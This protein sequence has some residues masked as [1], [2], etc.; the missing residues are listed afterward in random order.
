LV[1]QTPSQQNWQAQCAL[2]RPGVMRLWS[3]QAIAHGSESVM[4]FQW[5][6]T[7]GGIEKFHGAVIEHAGTPE[8]RVFREVAALGEELERLGT[9]TLGG[10]VPARVALLF[11][12]EN[13]WALTGSSGP[14]WDLIYLDICRAFFGAL[15]ETGILCD[16]VS[17]E[18][19]LSEYSIVVA[20]L[21]YMVKEGLDEKLTQFVHNG[22]TFLTTYFSGIADECDSVHLGGYP[23]P[24]RSLLGVWVE[25]LD[26]LSPK[27]SN[28]AVFEEAF[29][30]LNEAPCGLICERL[31]LEGA[32][33]LARFGDDFYAGEPAFTVHNVGAGHAYY[34]ATQFSQPALKDALR[35]VCARANVLPEIEN[36]PDE[37]EVM[38]RTAPDGCDLLYLLNHRAQSQKVSL[39]T[40]TWQELLTEK[41]TAGTIEIPAYGVAILRAAS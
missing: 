13:W 17:F 37:I 26:A 4:Y 33:A 34:L 14:S 11:D 30:E 16:I 10:R 1:E 41:A 21:L 7:R 15:H 2:K 20:P 23:G 39:P 22:G 25:E 28:R 38:R 29:G 24:L 40:G 8:A 5:R 19:D 36:L 18:T 35:E 6:R 32:H 3:Y 9:Q 27:E 31:H 12:W